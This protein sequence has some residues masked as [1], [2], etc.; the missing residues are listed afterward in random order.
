[1]KKKLVTIII[2]LSVA[3][4]ATLLTYAKEPCYV[5]MNAVVSYD[6][7]ETGI[8]LHFEDGTG[9]YLEKGEL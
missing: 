4:S 2:G 5:D 7:T 8:L 9:Y 1:M 3:L 6:V